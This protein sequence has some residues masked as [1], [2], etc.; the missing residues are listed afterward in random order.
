VSRS[1]YFA[2]GIQFSQDMTIDST[3]STYLHITSYNRSILLLAE[4][5]ESI[6]PFS[7][8]LIPFPIILSSLNLSGQDLFVER[9]FWCFCLRPEESFFGMMWQRCSREGCRRITG[10]VVCSIVCSSWASP[11]WCRLCSRRG[12][13]RGQNGRS[14]FR[15][16][17]SARFRLAH[18]QGEWCYS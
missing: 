8:P 5:N 4:P 18:V 16:I 1:Q 9:R 15:E 6:K 14:F 2:A 12:L 13:R 11:Y 17:R 7:T 10:S 3:L